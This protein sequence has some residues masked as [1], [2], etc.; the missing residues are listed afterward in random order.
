MTW[1][2]G[3]RGRGVAQSGDSLFKVT[4]GRWEDVGNEV[5]DLVSCKRSQWCVYACT[6]TGGLV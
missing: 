2:E 1:R 3:S 5:I 4:G 6:D